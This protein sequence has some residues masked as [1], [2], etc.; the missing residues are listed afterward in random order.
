MKTVYDVLVNQ[1]KNTDCRLATER[2]L[3]WN[4]RSKAK[5][6]RIAGLGLVAVATYRHIGFDHVVLPKWL[7]DIT[8]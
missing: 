5:A 8:C 6:R 1:G 2:V 4:H 3:Q 7:V